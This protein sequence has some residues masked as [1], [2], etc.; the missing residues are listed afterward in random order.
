MSDLEAT[1]LA[2]SRA[3][4]SVAMASVNVTVPRGQRDTR[5]CCVIGVGKEVTRWN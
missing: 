5:S 2:G 4:E 3:L 1:R